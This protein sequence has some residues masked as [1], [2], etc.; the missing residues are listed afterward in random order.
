M[1]YDRTCPRCEPATEDEAP[2]E[3]CA[4]C[5]AYHHPACWTTEC[6]SCR[7]TETLAQQ[8][9]AKAEFV[10]AQRS[11]SLFVGAIVLVFGAVVFVMVKDDP[12][13]LRF[14]EL[15][16]TKIVLV[17]LAAWWWSSWRR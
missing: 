3:C 5:G 17:V 16:F 6:A 13:R 15:P 1:T 4:R 2:R 14:F 7:G 11:A 9:A 8:K 10:A 12:S